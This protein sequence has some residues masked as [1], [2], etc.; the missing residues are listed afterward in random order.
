M[1]EPIVSICTL[2]YNHEPY[3]RQTLDSFL[4]QRDVPFEIII[5]DDASTDGSAEIIREYEKKY[6]D[7][8]KPMYQTENQYSKGIHNPSGAFNFPRAT[9]RYIAMCEGDDFW[10]D[11]C[12]L[13]KQ[14][15]YMDTHPECTLLAHSAHII[16]AD[17]A[18]RSAD[19]IRPYEEHRD[20]LPEEVISKPVSFPMASLMFPAELAKQLPRW[21]YE[22]PVGDIPLHLFMLEHGT[23]HYM[24]APMATYRM[25][26][27]GSWQQLM[28]KDPKTVQKWEDHYLAMKELFSAFNEETGGKYALPCEDAVRRTRFLVDLKIGNFDVVKD[29]ENE[30]Y[31]DELG[32]KEK[33]LLKLRASHP[34]LYEALQKIYKKFT[35][36]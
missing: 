9:G 22:C 24:D 7:V 25:G 10:N 17:G 16:P 21:Y 12:K 34:Q 19:L 35:N 30:K 28:D 32:A 20:L 18:W 5:H 2:S 8:V 15:E 6:P 3:L 29:P 4:S 27:E 26:R 31:M 36:P 11:P 13:K 33:K 23:V 14:V 1:K